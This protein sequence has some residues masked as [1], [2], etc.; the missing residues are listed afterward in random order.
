M[1]DEEIRMSD[2]PL[3]GIEPRALGARLREAREARGLTQGEVAKRLGVALTTMVAIEKGERQ[4]RPEELM[5]LAD[6]YER[7]VSELLQRG[8]RITSVLT[9]EDVLSPRD[10]AL[11]V[12]AWQL[13]E[14]SEGQLARFLRTDRLGAREAIQELELL[15][16]GM[17]SSADN[18]INQTSPPA[19]PT[20]PDPAR[21][22]RAASRDG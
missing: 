14:L 6:I 15:C 10:L 1:L 13:G 19:S 20:S 21:R 9:D 4:L 22:G 18:P 11:A 2:N 7:Q 5:E 3:D 12:E 17:A 16:G 8:A